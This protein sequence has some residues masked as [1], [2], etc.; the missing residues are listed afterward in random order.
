MQL[1]VRVNQTEALRRGINAP[2]STVKVEVDPA[3]LSQE[4][5]DLIASSLTDGFRLDMYDLFGSVVEPTQAGIVARAEEIIAARK[6][7]AEEQ[8]AYRAEFSAK[9]I[10]NPREH[11]FV[12]EIGYEGIRGWAIPGY[13]V[14][15]S[16]ASA[17]S[18]EL[19]P[20]AIAVANATIRELKEELAA[21]TA[22]E[23]AKRAESKRK[24][25]DAAAAKR[26][27]L[28]GALTA[29]YPED[30]ERFAAGFMNEDEAEKI[31]ADGYR[32]NLGLE[33][34]GS[35]KQ[36]GVDDFDETKTLSAKAFAALKAFKQKLP[37]GAVCK[38]F[39][40]APECG[41]ESPACKVVAEATFLHP[42][43]PGVEIVA[44]CLLEEVD[45]EA[46]E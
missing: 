29:S 16:R 13:C 6:K 28:L 31:I 24:Q 3:Q 26:S 19:T 40:G 5:R 2:A 10:A 45:I 46:S 41:S 17:E 35:A 8:A 21:R 20:E 14:N 43:I 27:A 9:L 11:V 22:K 4:V 7:L 12:S 39:E 15:P 25:D 42:T 44:D 23:A 18:A 37:E 1:Q 33:L 30:G 32:A 36:W 38:V 34:T